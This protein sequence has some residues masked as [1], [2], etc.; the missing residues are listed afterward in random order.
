[1]AAT[2]QDVMTALKAADASGNTE[3]AARLAEIANSMR[4]KYPRQEM[5]TWNQEAEQAKPEGNIYVE[6]AR[7]GLAGGLATASGAANYLS[8]ALKLRP[9]L[10]DFTQQYSAI[11]QPAMEILGS[12]GA[13]PQTMGEKILT[14]GVEVAADPLSYILPSSKFIDAAAPIKKYV[15]KAGEALF[16]GAGSEVGG[17]AGEDIGQKLGGETG[18]Q[19]GRVA[20]ALTGGVTGNVAF[21]TVPRSSA[22]YSAVAPKVKNLYSKIRGTAPLKEVQNQAAK[23]IENVW[24]AAAAADPNFLKVLEEATQAQAKTGVKLPLSAVLADNPV[25]NSYIAHLSSIDPQFKTQYFAQFEAAKAQLTGKSQKLFGAASGADTSLIKNI[26]DIDITSSVD[27]RKLALG[28][29]A[30]RTS[31]SL[32]TV[33][34]SDFGSGVVDVTEKAEKSAR[35]AATPAYTNA[36][37]IGNSKGVELSKEAVEDIHGYVTGKQSGDI[38][39]TFPTIHSKIVTKFNPDDAAGLLDAAGNPVTGGGYKKASLED[40]D[41]LKKEVNL[42]LRK[43]K[44]DSEI[45]LLTELKKKVA[46]HIDQLDPEF[47]AAYKAA[48]AGYLQK[49]GLPFNEETINQI[50]RAKFDENVIPLLT[51]NKSTLQQFVDATGDSGKKLAKEAFISDLA[52]FAV[53][54]GVLNPNKAKMWMTMKKDALSLLPDVRERVLK[55]STDVQE[56]LNHQKALGGKFLKVAEARILKLE[57]KSAQEITSNMYRSQEFT[58]RFMAQHGNNQDNLKAIRSFML[59][60]ILS[61]SKPLEILADRSKAATYN[62][63]FGKGYSDKVKQL[64]V[65][66][67]RATKDPSNVA[68]NLPSIDK[69]IIDAAVGTA[70]E[71]IYSLFFTNPV[72]SKQVAVMTVLSRFFN[73]TTSALAD[74]E[75]K[76]ILL[77]PD[78]AVLLFKAVQPRVDKLSMSLAAKNLE[79]LAKKSG[80]NFV[81]MLAED[82][83]SGALR[84]TKGMDTESLPSEQEQQE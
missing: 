11:K 6:A 31:A 26:K 17:I 80:V 41:S 61:S 70:P 79:A 30:E 82:I 15:M 81:T 46:S 25:I 37:A 5:S 28:K 2:Y 57:G 14:T 66:A 3:D 16:A 74:K 44:T 4:T 18:G 38:F 21:G 75:M 54:D 50:G 8:G 20:G 34:P 59:D 77:D 1:M 65:I 32:K 52:H 33:D 51:K 35:M 60:D 53:K 42:Q 27:R 13:Q 71:R 72:V 22:A 19:I 84:S 55:S 78:K 23:H 39:K 58:M 43:T 64:A 9:R 73:R 63:I 36:F 47:V 49:V 48:D 69:N 45:R 83:R 24:I 56:L 67:D 68:V 62:R 12:T 10:S 40:L 29:Q 7:K 76:E